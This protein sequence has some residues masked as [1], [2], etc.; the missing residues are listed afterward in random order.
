[1]SSSTPHIILNENEGVVDTTTVLKTDPGITVCMP[2]GQRLNGLGMMV[3]QYLEQ[4]FAQFDHK[5]KEGLRI[6]GRVAV[7]VEKGI[8][9]TLW[10]QGERVQIENGVS[11]DPDLYIKS[12]YLLLSKVLSGKSNPYV[13]ILR[14]N[15]K[16]L[17]LPR[18][19]VQ[20][21]RVLRFLKIPP[22]LL[23]EPLPSRRKQYVLYVIGTILGMA[24]M[25]L[26]IY[27][28]YHLFG[29]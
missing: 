27:Q 7:E 20:G 10:F 5:V 13:E 15:I 24:G 9:I 8:A 16:L 17:A 6:R 14:G 26:L 12:S 22:E 19:P 29:N 25:S 23:L 21:L 1:M 2:E 4:N 18:R 28:L 11:E 3:L